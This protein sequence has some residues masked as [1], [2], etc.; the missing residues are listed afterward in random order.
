MENK[1][2]Y[3]INEQL[4]EKLKK[5]YNLLFVR[6]NNGQTVYIFENIPKSYETLKFSQEEKDQLIFSNKLTF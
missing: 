4:K 2:I 6:E 3:C 5:N 1:F